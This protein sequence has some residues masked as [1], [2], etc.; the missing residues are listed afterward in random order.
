MDIIGTNRLI[1]KTVH[2]SELY[3]VQVRSLDAM[4]GILTDRLSP[5]L[6]FRTFVGSVGSV[7]G[8]DEFMRGVGQPRTLRQP[9]RNPW[10]ESP[11]PEVRAYRAALLENIPKLIA[12][13]PPRVSSPSP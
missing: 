5:G 3:I 8:G 6:D 10:L 4:N 9:R 7:G 11:N 2:G 12:D 1:K 13:L